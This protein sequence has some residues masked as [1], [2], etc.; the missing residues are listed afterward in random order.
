MKDRMGNEFSKEKE[1]SLEMRIVVMSDNVDKAIW[2]LTRACVG[3]RTKEDM[4]NSINT[5]VK[6]LIDVRT[7]LTGR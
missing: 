3:K 2:E 1:M 5:A 6:L 7:A 4:K